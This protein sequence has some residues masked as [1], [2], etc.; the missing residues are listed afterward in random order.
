MTTAAP[1]QREYERRE[2]QLF[3]YAL[4]NGL[5]TADDVL[6][7]AAS[8][9]RYTAA[10]L[11]S[12]VKD[13]QVTGKDA[14]LRE[15]V[16]SLE[17]R[18]FRYLVTLQANQPWR[19]GRESD[20]AALLEA[21]IVHGRRD[22]LTR[23]DR[24]NFLDILT[25]LDRRADL[26][27]FISDFD[28]GEVGIVQAHLLRANASHPFSTGSEDESSPGVK[29]WLELV[30]WMFIR[31]GLEPIALA[32]GLE[33]P[34]DRVL[35]APY[36]LV[37]DGPLV[38]VV[39][40][41]HNPNLSVATALESL[42]AQSY[43]PLE[44]LIMNDGSR[45]DVAVSLEEWESR[46]PRIRVVHLAE[47][48]GPYF[49][50][51]TGASTYARGDYITVHDDDDWSHP[52]KIELQVAH[53]LA[54]PDLL[55]NLSP[56]CRL[57][58]NL[59]MMRRSR[60]P[61]YAHSNFSSL[62]IRR[63]VMDRLGNWD[64]VNRGADGEMR[65]RIMAV[66]GAPIPR[67]TRAPMSLLRMTESSLTSGELNRGYV[68]PRR[69][70]YSMSYGIWHDRTLASGADPYLPP[71]DSDCR[72]F[73]VPVAM[74]G[75]RAKQRP[76]TVDVLY[77]T[78][79]R[80]AGGHSE[81][82]SNE[83]EILLG[84]GLTVG[85]LQ[86]DSP[87]VGGSPRLQPRAFDLA[88]HPGA[89]VLSMKDA[90]SARL[91]VIRHPAVLQFVEPERSPIS[92]GRVV[93]VVD[94]PPVSPDGKGALYD[95]SAVAANCEVTLGTAA[96]LAPQSAGIRRLLEGIVDPG[97]LAPTD[98]GSVVRLPG[99]PPRTAHPSRPPRLGKHSCDQ[100]VDDL[101]AELDFWVDFGSRDLDE[102][103]GMATLE[104][105]AAG[106]VV[107][108]P[109]SMRATFGEGAIYADAKLVGALVDSLWA[110]PASYHRQSERA[111]STVKDRF[112][113]ASL[114]A[115]VNANLA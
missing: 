34:L 100:P 51:N 2:L 112:G 105:M 12:T 90:A 6:A 81:L 25:T 10:E 3:R 78:D 37:E 17:V 57:T 13:L 113:E 111:I 41:T 20:A 8:G 97:I 64:L 50:R 101:L 77:A 42:I 115:R 92:A 69:R 35:C 106:L 26:A 44:I 73:P 74:V 58:P 18:P 99:G 84:H 19:S 86:L 83:I 22:A 61:K 80:L 93:L 28:L 45:P 36:S 85:M 21:M 95:V 31:D 29:A 108:L 60:S 5:A 33:P 110:D 56:G 75:A 103:F 24:G 4:V 98:W 48:R 82:T 49:A 59:W 39:M 32:P 53:L 79:F 15:L 47:N 52:R 91:T 14:E 71:D 72:P 63:D 38:T 94:Q 96:V 27:R 40:P 55:A 11:V 46:D 23:V 16:R 87:V 54:N 102:S 114:L 67:A 65:S 104:A 70:W 30:N 76:T 89:R 7:R 109:K 1:L 9:G 62:L 68:D 66:S 43:R 88:S 107:I